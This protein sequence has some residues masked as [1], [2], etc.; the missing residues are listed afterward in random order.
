MNN[1]YFICTNHG[2][3]HTN[4]EKM[5]QMPFTI[6]ELIANHSLLD[7]PGTVPSNMNKIFFV[8]KNGKDYWEF[9]NYVDYKWKKSSV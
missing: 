8:T 4:D 7:D 9:G 3:I 6:D 5:A 1:R 2:Y